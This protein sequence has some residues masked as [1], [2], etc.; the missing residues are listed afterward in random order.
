[1]LA[2]ACGPIRRACAGH[3]GRRARY[4][5]GTNVVSFFE[6]LRSVIRFEPIETDP[7]ERR[8]RRAACVA[9]LRRLAKRRLPGGVFDYIDGAA[10]DERTNA[11][12]Q[13]AFAH[14]TFR[15]RVLRGLE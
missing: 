11:A 9:D 10:E 15:P 2:I 5:G 8:L 6:T 7:V 4:C 13:A 1:M 14:T 12:N 3:Y